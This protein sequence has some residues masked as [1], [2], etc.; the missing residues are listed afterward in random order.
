MDKWSPNEKKLKIQIPTYVGTIWY[1][2]C[3]DLK[4]HREW[5]MELLIRHY[6]E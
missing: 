5:A 1:C 2:Q 4:I 6:Y 3:F